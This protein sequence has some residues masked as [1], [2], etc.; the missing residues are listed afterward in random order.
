MLKKVALVSG[1]IVSLSLVGTASAAGDIAAGKA[2]SGTCVGCHGTDGIS[3]VPVY[4]NLAG[5][6][7]AYTAKQLKAFRDKIRVD[8]VMTNQATN[9]T[10]ADIANLAAYYES[11]KK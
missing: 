3:F 5:Q 1:L 6:K 8:P 4:P 9:L 2:K 10:D 7:A 11:L